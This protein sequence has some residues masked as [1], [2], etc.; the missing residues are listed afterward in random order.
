MT[1]LTNREAIAKEMANA[2]WSYIRQMLV[3][4]QLTDI[5]IERIGFHYKTAF[6][7]GFKHADQISVARGA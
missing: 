2:H 3:H 6:E 4:D 1:E 5:E 7:H